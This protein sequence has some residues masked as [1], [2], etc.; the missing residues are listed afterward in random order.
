[1]SVDYQFKRCGQFLGGSSETTVILSYTASGGLGF[2]G[3]ANPPDKMSL[4]GSSP[5]MLFVSY[6]ASGGLNLGGTVTRSDLNFN[7]SAERTFNLYYSAGGIENAATD[8]K[9]C[10]CCASCN[11]IFHYEASG[12]LN[13]GGTA[14]IFDLNIKG[15]ADVMVTYLYTASG[16]LSIGGY[17]WVSRRYISTLILDGHADA[18]LVLPYAASGGLTLGGSAEDLTKLSLSGSADST[19]SLF[20]ASSGS[21]NIGGSAFPPGRLGFFGSATSRVVFS[22]EASGGLGV[23]GSVRGYVHIYPNDPTPAYLILN[24]SGSGG[25]VD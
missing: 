24:Y 8:D 17:A 12:G 25:W 11:L 6:E 10:A 1:M 5:M 19:F 15:S 13:L 20:Y 22:Y 4:S 23:C 3:S 7:G 9:D 21:L 18:V 14:D 16:K 2:G